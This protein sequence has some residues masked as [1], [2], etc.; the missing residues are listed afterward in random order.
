MRI[1][2]FSPTADRAAVQACHEIYLAGI[3]VDD[4]NVPPMRPRTFAGWLEVGWTEDPRESWLARHRKQSIRSSASS[5]SSGRRAARI[6]TMSR[7]CIS[8]VTV[9]S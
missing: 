1:E 7:S 6:P 5:T 4:P 9:F 8:P 3:P 2:Q